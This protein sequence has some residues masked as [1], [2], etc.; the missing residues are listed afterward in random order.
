MGVSE[1][2]DSSFWLGKDPLVAMAQQV[3]KAL[4]KRLEQWE[5][6]LT[7]RAAGCTYREIGQ[8]LGVT[9]SRARKIVIAALENRKKVVDE[10]AE[11]V[12]QIELERLDAL[13]KS[14]WKDRGDFHVADTL[15]RISERRTRLLGIEAA[16]KHEISGKDGGPITI[17][18]TRARN[19]ELI[20]QLSERVAVPD[21]GSSEPLAGG[22]AGAPE[23]GAAG[24]RDPATDAGTG[25]GVSVGLAGM[26][27][28][29]EPG[30]TA[31]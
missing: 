30:S 11:E 2:G 16:I 27:G 22:A 6:A 12:V 4:P 9:L 8:L 18:D 15:V 26:V 24:E 21:P 10:K 17:E 5:K 28:E 14:L 20:N 3:P 19:L 7:A 25:E 13:T 29:T 1:S 23:P 31:G